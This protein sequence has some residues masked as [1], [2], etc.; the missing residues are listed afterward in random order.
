MIRLVQKTIERLKL[1][2]QL[3]IASLICDALFYN[4][5]SAEIFRFSK[6]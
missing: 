5:L 2:I 3:R 6:H 1:T 4:S